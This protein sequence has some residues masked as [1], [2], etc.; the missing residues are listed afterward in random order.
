MK[1]F[2]S[3]ISGLIFLSLCGLIILLYFSVDTQQK[4]EIKFIDVSG[5]IYLDKE[6]YTQ[7]AKV[8][9][10]KSFNDLTLGTIKD[11]F[12]KHPY[13]D[14]VDLKYDGNG[15]V[16]VEIH[17]KNFRAIMITQGSEFLVDEKLRVV[18]LLSFTKNID[19]PVILGVDKKI[20]GKKN[21]ELKKAMKLISAA[22]LSNQ[23]LASDISEVE[24]GKKNNVTIRFIYNDYILNLGS[25][26]VIYKLAA[27]GSIYDKLN[28]N[29]G[30][31]NLKYIDMRFKD[32]IC[33][34][35]REEIPSNGDTKS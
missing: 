31:N 15:K 5:N 7:F 6:S 11:R 29:E 17:E 8:T 20:S 14:Y 35:F 19:L 2:S 30:V 33:L 24:L 21:A 25:E 23:A 3:K 22:E 4:Q 16:S 32:Q 18:P 13:I 10:R 28:A 34:G 26:D 1:N 27:F 9:E 12:E